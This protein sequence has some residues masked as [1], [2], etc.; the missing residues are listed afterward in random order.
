MLINSRGAHRRSKR[1][2]FLFWFSMW[3]RFD[4]MRSDIRCQ[5]FFF[6]RILIE[7]FSEMFANVWCVGSA[8]RCE[9]SGIVFRCESCLN[10]CLLGSSSLLRFD[11]FAHVFV[12]FAAFGNEC[13]L[14]I[15]FWSAQLV[16]HMAIRKTYATCFIVSISTTESSSFSAGRQSNCLATVL[17]YSTFVEAIWAISKRVIREHSV[18]FG[19]IECSLIFLSQ[20]RRIFHVTSTHRDRALPH[21]SC[22]DRL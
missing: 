6:S 9:Q 19:A 10:K 1:K 17:K 22:N 5:V 20:T 4:A 3:C 12:E 11:N 18:E 16:G 7:W 2:Y 15:S 13:R 21:T 14:K 8:I